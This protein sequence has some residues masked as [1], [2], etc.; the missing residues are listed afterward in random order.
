[1]RNFEKIEEIKTGHTA[2]KMKCFCGMP[3]IFFEGRV[4]IDLWV[5]TN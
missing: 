1:M 3:L 2:L 4:I 5:R